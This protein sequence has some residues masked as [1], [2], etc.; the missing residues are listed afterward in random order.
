[1]TLRKWVVV[2]YAPQVTKV[3][4]ALKITAL[5]LEETARRLFKEVSK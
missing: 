4:V 3:A 1:M 2:R 5:A